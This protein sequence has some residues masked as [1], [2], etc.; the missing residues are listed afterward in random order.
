MQVISADELDVSC[1]AVANVADEFRRRV[2]YRL[3]TCG[4]AG[5]TDDACLVTA[6]LVPMPVTRLP[7]SGS[8]SG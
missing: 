5:V 2:D 7:V 3:A 4:L 6:E 8:S 1:V